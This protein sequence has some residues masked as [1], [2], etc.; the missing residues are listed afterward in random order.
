M[1]EKTRFAILL[2][3]FA[4]SLALLWLANSAATNVVL[5]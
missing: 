4:A 2:V 3:L 5:N 1:S